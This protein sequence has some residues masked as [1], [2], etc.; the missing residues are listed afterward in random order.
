MSILRCLLIQQAPLLAFVLL[1]ALQAPAA[2]D[3]G[4]IFVASAEGV[5]VF[6][7]DGAM[8]FGHF[9]TSAKD[10]GPGPLEWDDMVYDGW[11]LPSGNYL[12]SSHRYVRELSAA[13][14]LLWEYRLEAPNELKTCVPLPNGDVMTVDASRMELVQITDHGKREVKRIPVP[15]APESQEHNRYNLLRR[16]AEGT[17]LLALRHEKAFIEVDEN[18]KELW[19]HPVPDLP[20]VAERLANGNTLMSWKN[21]L[22]EAAPDHSVVW[23]LNTADLT[24]FPVTIFGGFHRFEN[25]NTLIANSDWHYKEAGGNRVQLF[26]VDAKKQVVWKLTTDDFAGKKPGSLEP[27][28]GMVEQRIIGIQWL[29]EASPIAFA[30]HNETE[31]FTASVLPILVKNCYECHSHEGKIK[32]GLALDSAAGLRAGG[33]GG[34]IIVPGD[35]GKSRL[36]TAVQHVD[37]TF[38]MPPD[39]KLSDSEIEVLAEWIR[40]GAPDPRASEAPATVAANDEA[41]AWDALYQ[42][43]LKWWSLQPLAKSTPPEVRDSTWPRNEV[44]RFILSALEA[45]ELHPAEVANPRSLARRLS[46]ALTGL[47]PAPEMVAEFAANPTSEAYDVLV[48]S[49]LDSPHFG[50]RWARHWMDV[51]HYA[52]THGYEWDAPAKNAWLYRDYL[53]RAFNEDV[54][55]KQLILEQLAGDLLPPRVDKETGLNQAIIGPMALRLGERRHGDNGDAEGVTQEA[56][57]NMIDT[58]SKG[59]LATTVACAQCH[60]HKLDAVPQTD[61]YSLAGV[62]M[63]SRFPVRSAEAADPNGPVVASLREVKA[64]I[65]DALG[66]TWSEA[67]EEITRR[68]LAPPPEPETDES[69]NQKA[70]KDEPPAELPFPESMPAL[71]AYLDDRSEKG[72]DF[73][74]AWSD[75]AKEFR[76]IRAVRISANADNLS[77]LADFTQPEMPYGWKADGLGMKYGLVAEGELVV[78][79]EGDAAALH[80]L[81]AGRWSHVWSKRLGGAL[82]SDLFAQDPPP[83]I[84]LAYAGGD[85][86]AQSLIVDN[87]FHSERMK[88]LKQPLPGWLTFTAGNLTALAGGQYDTPRDIYLELVTKSFNNYYPPRD[89]FGGLPREAEDDPRSWFGVTRAWQTTPGYTPGDELGRF[90]ALYGGEAAPANRDELAGRF[91]AIILSAVERWREHTCDSEDVRLINEALQAGW[92]PNSLS[93]GTVLA[94]QVARYRA[95]EQELQPEQVVG[96]VD[97]WHEGRDARMGIRGSYTNLGEAVPRG[98]ISFLGGPGARAY[99][100]G[101]GRL[102]LA[103]N[104]ARDDNPLTARVY[105]NRVWH[106]LFGEGIVRTV[107][108]FGHLGEQPTHP[109]LLD[110]LAQRFMDEGWSTKKLI[111]LLVSSSTWRQR[112]VPYPAAVTADPE[113]RLLHHMPLRRLE[114]ESIRDTMLAASGRLNDCLYGPPINPYRVAEDPTK[115]LYC[116]P[117]DGDGRR[118]IYQKMTMMEPPKFLATFNQP[119]P[120]LTTGKRDATNVPNQAL[121][122]LNDPFVVAMAEHWSQRA[123][124]T[125]VASPAE[126]IEDM[127]TAAFARPPQPEETERFVAFAEQSAALRGVD[128][129]TLLD[130]QPVWQDVAH[131][132]FNMKEFIYVQ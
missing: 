94:E 96:S 102:E 40:Q 23:E 21:G 22:I 45:N 62:L 4:S 5:S 95:I 50:E 132:I 7:R 64:A 69:K 74:S 51:V 56:V 125:K 33:D 20:V 120:K 15:T 126:R 59:F 34:P 18:G 75:L 117:L 57:T 78:A 106:Y 25:G 43:R 27:S 24:D 60:D 28:T 31:F 89:R 44:D 17:F 100:D 112:S 98:T 114:A 118:S 92:L 127:F 3:A 16:T 84:A 42:E 48:Q 111:H 71:L 10:G 130:C 39:S 41:D 36:I 72:T 54:P 129:A 38:A 82:R 115:R 55:F 11:K 103:R 53:I 26:E 97:D 122:L 99:S 77:L 63:S 107:D 91:S 68:I 37:R 2:P 124:E 87:A 79:E 86:S 121:A 76:A 52:D 70:K 8:A 46:F 35:P 119:I 14:E 9:V 30:A 6:D 108:D 85:F 113:N 58:V 67:S 90:E 47:P 65:R 131:S 110:W 29:A 61:Y 73:S 109:E 80:L 104:I 49:F 128:P 83:V 32:G 81:P 1:G 19:R 88:F 93:A 116:G 13:G 12:F 101:S 66:D 105:V 123:L